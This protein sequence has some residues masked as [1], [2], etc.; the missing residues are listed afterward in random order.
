[1]HKE[2]ENVSVDL[3]FNQ[4]TY[5]EDRDFESSTQAKGGSTENSQLSIE[6]LI[7]L[8]NL[9]GWKENDKYFQQADTLDDLVFS[10][11][12]RMTDAQY[13]SAQPNVQD[14]VDLEN[15]TTNPSSAYWPGPLFNNTDCS[16]VDSH[17]S[18]VLEY[19]H[20]SL[21]ILNPLGNTEFRTD[22]END[23]RRFADLEFEIDFAPAP[24]GM[25]GAASHYR[26]CQTFLRERAQTS[27]APTGAEDEEE[28]DEMRRRRR[29]HLDRGLGG[30]GGA[31]DS[32]GSGDGSGD[33][34]GDSSGDGSGNDNH[35]GSP[36]PGKGSSGGG[37]GA[38]GPSSSSPSSG[39]SHDLEFYYW[40]WKTAFDAKHSP[41]RH[42]Q[43]TKA[44][45][46][47]HAP[48]ATLPWV[49]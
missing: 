26:R 3:G 21:Y 22:Y 39:N 46:T 28:D 11:D 12:V 31:D 8:G 27:A 19:P 37:A 38:S 35:D 45:A 30:G 13:L 48:V 5:Q 43:E 1:M 17:P 49:R 6:Q 25:A 32:D 41:A 15:F 36:G 42:I 40:Q 4:A 7:I 33:G 44:C 14:G 20:H 16:P 18:K 9:D 23:P 29:R 34:Y 47:P 24:E 2:F 10:E